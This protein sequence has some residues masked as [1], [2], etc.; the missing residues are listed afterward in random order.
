MVRPFHMHP[1]TRRRLA[2]LVTVLLLWQQVAL[3]A[4]VCPTLPKATGQ[5][6][7]MTSM[8]AVDQTCAQMQGAPTDPLCDKHCLPDHATQVDVRTASVPLNVLTALPPMLLSVAA[9]T[10]PSNRTLARLDR[11]RAPP[12]APMLLYCTLLI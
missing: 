12:P 3:A 11:L 8:P 9:V 6:T 5:S 2:W 10:L 7:A 4:Y 1:A